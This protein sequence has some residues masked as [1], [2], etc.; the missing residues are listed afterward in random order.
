[1]FGSDDADGIRASTLGNY[2][3][4]LTDDAGSR[5]PSIKSNPSVISEVKLIVERR[6]DPIT[7]DERLR[8]FFLCLATTGVRRSRGSD[9]VE[10]RQ[11]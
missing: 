6:R 5:W 8:T 9:F 2:R 3:H 7:A 11:V 10:A 4:V 1:M